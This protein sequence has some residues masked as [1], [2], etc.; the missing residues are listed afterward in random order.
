MIDRDETCLS[1]LD[2]LNEG[3]VSLAQA[4]LRSGCRDVLHLGRDHLVVAE[5][6]AGQWVGAAGVVVGVGT[7][8]SAATELVI[9]GSGS[10]L[11]ITAEE[12]DRH[13]DGGCGRAEHDADRLMNQSA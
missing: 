2:L 8:D 3:D 12:T 7:G 6:A 9:P 1:S 10:R 5:L 11:L 4:H 13:H